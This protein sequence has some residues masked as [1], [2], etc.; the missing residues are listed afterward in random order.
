[1]KITCFTAAFVDLR[2]SEPEVFIRHTYSPGEEAAHKE[3]TI[4]NF[5]VG[6][7]FHQ[8]INISLN[9][10]MEPYWFRLEKLMTTIYESYLQSEWPFLDVLCAV[11]E[12]EQIFRCNCNSHS[13]Q[14][15]IV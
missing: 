3:I 13:G 6:G 2:P 1:M 4:D 7:G 10:P 11:E 12:E 14:S 5:M 15:Y 8:T 9:N